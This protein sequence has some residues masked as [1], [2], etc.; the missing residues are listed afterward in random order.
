MEKHKPPRPVYTS[1]ICIVCDYYAH[2]IY[3]NGKC[4]Q[5]TFEGS[6][7]ITFCKGFRYSREE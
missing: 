5:C 1:C 6:E 3:C 4:G 7:V 2:C